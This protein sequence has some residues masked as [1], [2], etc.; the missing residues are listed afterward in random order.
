MHNLR[1]HLACRVHRDCHN[2]DSGHTVASVSVTCTETRM[3]TARGMCRLASENPELFDTAACTSAFAGDRSAFHRIS[4]GAG[5]GGDAPA[6]RLCNNHF[7]A[8]GS[9]VA[10]AGGALQIVARSALRWVRS[11]Y[12]WLRRL[13]SSEFVKK[14]DS[15]SSARSRS[16]WSRRGVVCREVHRVCSAHGFCITSA[17]CERDRAV[18]LCAKS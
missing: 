15:L 2:N 18:E 1:C 12:D 8:S 13:S 7:S 6:R 9:P 3:Q 16:S 11:F 4:H 17:M 5:R 14:S 10:T